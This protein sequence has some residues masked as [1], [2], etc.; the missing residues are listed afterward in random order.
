MEDEDTDEYQ[1]YRSN[2]PVS[3][4]NDEK[5]KD[6]DINMYKKMILDNDTHFFDLEVNTTHSS[7]HVPT[8][9]Y[10]KRKCN[11]QFYKFVRLIYFRQRTQICNT[12]VWRTG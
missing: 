10:H 11:F 4:Y 5:H 2:P 7:V 1:Y 3:I 12:V 9:I 8:N 6:P